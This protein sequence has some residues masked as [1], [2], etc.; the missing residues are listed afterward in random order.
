MVD[1]DSGADPGGSA[2]GSAGAPSSSPS[3]AGDGAS[4]V[5]SAPGSSPGSTSQGLPA[6]GDSQPGADA[7]FDFLFDTQGPDPASSPDLST[8]PSPAPTATAPQTPPQPAAAQPQPA[9]PQPAAPDPA[10]VASPPAQPPQPAAQSPQSLSP[11]DPFGLARALQENSEAAITDLAQ[12]VFRLDQKD[13]E[14][15][16]TDVAGTVPRLLAKTFVFAQQQF[17]NQ[18]G[19]VIP[20]MMARMAE[21]MRKQSDAENQFYSAWPQLDRGKHADQV[22]ELGIRYR[23]M[24]PDHNLD[25]MVKNLGPLVLSAV[26]LPLVAPTAS[27]GAAAARPT[28]VAPVARAQGFVPAAPGAVVSVGQP[29]ADPFGYMGPQPD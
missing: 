26:G 24:F 23:K 8:A 17:L 6:S 9:Q 19:H 20:A 12:G 28:N 2:V 4:A 22:R 3:S 15:L 11:A 10:A 29:E 14:G 13:L 7:S 25:Q 21:T 18:M 1:P 27:A 16:E 5:S